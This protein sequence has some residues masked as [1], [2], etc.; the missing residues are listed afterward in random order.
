VCALSRNNHHDE[1]SNGRS[2]DGKI[3]TVAVSRRGAAAPSNTNEGP[4]MKRS[5]LVGA[6]M[7]ALVFAAA[8][9]SDSTSP[10]QITSDDVDQAAVISAS[11]ATAEDVSILSASDMTMSGGAVQ[12][13]VGA[14]MSLSRTPLAAPSYAWTFGDGCTYSS[15][16]GRFSCPPITA[17]GLTLNRDYA[18]F[19]A[20]QTAQSAYSASLTASA[21]FHVSVAG[22]HVADA[23]ADTVN[24]DRS[25]TVTGLSGAETSR[26]WNGTGTRAD[27]GYRT[28]GDV[29]RNY[30][31]SDALTVSNVV[32]NLP[33]ST[34]MWPISGT[35]TRQI[36]GTASVTKADVSKSFSVSR[37]VTITFNG[38]Q[39]ATVTVGGNTYTLDL[40]TG[41]ATKN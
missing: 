6:P 14:G 37:T 26:T 10:I 8:C 29:K 38:T 28:N 19:D 2:A 21:N 18:F 17:G 5:L 25:L 40:S 9:S 41:V 35:I 23:G 20:N 34:N 30:H 1:T 36:S 22:V 4:S 31:T 11:D 7:L 16:T 33:R 27:G 3:P 13:V 12:N 15:T 32:V 24:R 39:N